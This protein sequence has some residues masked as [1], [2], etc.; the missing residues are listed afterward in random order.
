MHMLGVE[1]F[2]VVRSLWVVAIFFSDV[3]GGVGGGGDSGR[4][5]EGGWRPGGGHSIDK[6]KPI[7]S[8]EN[9]RTLVGYFGLDQPRCLV[10]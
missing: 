10:I 4:H 5:M 6:R 9:I 1:R 8:K 7:V 3:A 2:I